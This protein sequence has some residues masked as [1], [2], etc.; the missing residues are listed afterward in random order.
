MSEFVWKV[1]ITRKRRNHVQKYGQD[2]FV[3]VDEIELSYNN[4]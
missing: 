2:F 4:I 1:I 3:V